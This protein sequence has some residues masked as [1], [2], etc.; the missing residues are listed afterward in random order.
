MKS[1]ASKQPW[2]REEQKILSELLEQLRLQ[3]PGDARESGKTA[4][5]AAP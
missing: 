2:T 4:G 1:A 3:Q 5:D